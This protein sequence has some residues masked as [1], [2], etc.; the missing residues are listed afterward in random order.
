[1]TKEEKKKIYMK[2][3][4]L[5]NKEKIAANKK[6]YDRA[7]Y[8]A[9]KE[10][11][12]SKAR[13]YYNNNQEKIKVYRESVKDKN[14]IKDKIYYKANREKLVK[15]MKAR[16]EA[17]K[18]DFYTLYFIPNHNYVGVTNQTYARMN[19]HRVKNNKDTTNWT[20]IK[21]FKTKREALDAERFYHSIGYEGAHKQ[22]KLINPI[23]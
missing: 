2:A 22:L 15:G 18:T 3:Y 11:I 23:I 5:A 9:N 8:E 17:R 13:D 4:R 12:K 7:R 20:T 16:R 1:M 10:A 6:D 19:N 14:A 21:T